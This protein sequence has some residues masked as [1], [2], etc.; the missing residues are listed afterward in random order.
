MTIWLS[1]VLVWQIAEARIVDGG[2]EGNQG[3]VSV[4]FE[5]IVC[6]MASGSG[7]TQDK[8]EELFP[9]QDVELNQFKIN[10]DIL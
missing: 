8:T 4:L 7:Y 9:E 3:M 5:E 1:S 10:F 2:C 6:I